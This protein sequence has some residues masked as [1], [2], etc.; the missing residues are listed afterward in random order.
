MTVPQPRL[1][2][3]TVTL[4][5]ATGQTICYTMPAPRDAAVESDRNHRDLGLAIGGPV[6]IPRIF[7]VQIAFA[8]TLEPWGP[9]GVS[10][11]R[12]TAPE[13]GP[14]GQIAASL[15]RIQSAYTGPDGPGPP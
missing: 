13:T 15:A 4:E 5:L 11:V 3:A 2:R 7:P 14:A 6:E 9:A 12:S 8:F 1:I 10:L